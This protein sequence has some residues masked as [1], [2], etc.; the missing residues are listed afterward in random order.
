MNA[1]LPPRQ[2]HDAD[3]VEAHR[4]PPIA[5]SAASHASAPQHPASK[6]PQSSPQAQPQGKARAGARPHK[7][8]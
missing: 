8:T 7:R 4:L 1:L 5:S 6:A 2:Y 3:P